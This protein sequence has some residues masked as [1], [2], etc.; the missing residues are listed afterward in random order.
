VEKHDEVDH[1]QLNLQDSQKHV[2]LFPDPDV[3]HHDDITCRSNRQENQNKRK[4]QQD[5][6]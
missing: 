6:E 2:L 1:V 4:Q 3:F 5:H